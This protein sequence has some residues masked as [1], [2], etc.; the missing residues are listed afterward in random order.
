MHGKLSSLELGWRGKDSALNSVLGL[1]L[2]DSRLRAL[3]G[4]GVEGWLS[5]VLHPP[6]IKKSSDPA[7]RAWTR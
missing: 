4:P 6:E 3:P 5:R 1:L 2:E 7:S